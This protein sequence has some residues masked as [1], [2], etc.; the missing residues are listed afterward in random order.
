MRRVL[1]DPDLARELRRRGLARS[2]TF[3]WSRTVAET[4]AAYRAMLAASS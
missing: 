4:V 1:E 2:A 3:S